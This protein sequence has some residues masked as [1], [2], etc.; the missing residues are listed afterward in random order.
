MKFVV[1]SNS[2]AYEQL[3]EALMDLETAPVDSY[4]AVVDDCEEIGR[5]AHYK[6]SDETNDVSEKGFAVK[7]KLNGS[8]HY[9]V[10]DEQSEAEQYY[11]VQVA[12][13]PTKLCLLLAGRFWLIGGEF[14]EVETEERLTDVLKI[15]SVN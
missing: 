11:E 4:I 7:T 15:N 1:K 8:C 12:E 9:A 10:F 14:L 2:P 5:V 3:A 6:A 13:N